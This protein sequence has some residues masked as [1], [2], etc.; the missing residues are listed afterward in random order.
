MIDENARKAFAQDLR[1]LA[2]GNISNDHFEDVRLP[3]TNT[4]DPAVAAI[5]REGAW[6][7]Y[8][9]LHEHTLRGRYALTRESKREVARWVLFLRSGLPY[10]WPEL[11]GWRYCLLLLANAMTLGFANRLYRRYVA[12]FGDTDVWPFLTHTD[13]VEALQHP[14]YLGGR[15]NS[16]FHRNSPAGAGEFGELGC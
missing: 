15:S 16:A 8:S 4:A 10:Q 13:Y 14:P 5:Y 12:R 7:L 11:R 2:A 9:D 1:A 6:C 3:A